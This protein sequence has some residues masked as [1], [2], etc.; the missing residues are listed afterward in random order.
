MNDRRLVL[1]D[2]CASPRPRSFNCRGAGVVSDPYQQRSMCWPRKWQCPCP[3]GPYLLV[4]LF[5]TAAAVM[6][7][8]YAAFECTFFRISGMSTRRVTVSFGL[9]TVEKYRS[10]QSEQ[11]GEPLNNIYAYKTPNTCTR[12]SKHEEINKSDID[13]PIRSARAMVL[14]A[15]I[16]SP[17]LLGY[18]YKGRNE[19]FSQVAVRAMSCGMLFTALLTGLSLVALQSSICQD[20]RENCDIG[21]AGYI[22]MAAVVFWVIACCTTCTLHGTYVTNTQMACWRGQ[23]HI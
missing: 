5:F 11:L 15:V 4:P 18:L 16:F 9:W 10:F 20:N 14:M 6:C 19:L 21:F 22:C 3:Y 13:M 2:L 7:T 17:F 12:W 1:Q 8:G 23:S